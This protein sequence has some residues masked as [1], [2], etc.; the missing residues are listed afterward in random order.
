MSEEQILERLKDIERRLVAIEERGSAS[1]QRATRG[2]AR[3]RRRAASDP[4]VVDLKV[5]AADLRQFVELKAPRSHQEKFAVLAHFLESKGIRRV[6]VDEIC[7][8]Y[9]LLPKQM[10]P[11]A[12]EKPPKAMEQVFRDC[13]NWFDA[14]DDEGRRGL[15]HVGRTHVEFD[16]PR[17][18]R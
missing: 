4:Q 10:P 1:P 11:K 9:L 3:T 12:I 7:T 15:T 6:G 8:A 14:P 18:K 17:A 16:L 5:D 13:P 2:V